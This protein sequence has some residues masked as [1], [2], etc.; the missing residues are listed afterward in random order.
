MAAGLHP[1]AETSRFQIAIPE[2][3]AFA[4]TGFFAL[5]P[6]GRKV[7]FLAVKDHDRQI[8]IRPVDSL[9]AHPLPGTE[10]AFS[11]P[12]FWSPDSRFVAF[13]ADKKI[14]GKSTSTAARRRTLVTCRRR[15]GRSADRG[16]A[17]T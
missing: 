17:T 8:W 11:S 3:M 13:E 16:T 15:V 14:S 10:N 4:A 6:D 9:E 1:P 7:A 12:F 5:S 2:N